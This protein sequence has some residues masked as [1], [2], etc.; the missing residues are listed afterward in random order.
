MTESCGR[1]ASAYFHAGSSDAELFTELLQILARLE[2]QT[3]AH[4]SY[5]DHE[6][7]KLTLYTALSPL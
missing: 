2:L 3:I 1:S 5:T 6:P 7:D 4:R